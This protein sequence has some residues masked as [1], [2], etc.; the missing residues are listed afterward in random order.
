MYMMF[1]ITSGAVQIGVH[2]LPE[3]DC[4]VILSVSK[5]IFD[6]FKKTMNDTV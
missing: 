1:C 4:N 5:Q 3:I 6:G 2:L